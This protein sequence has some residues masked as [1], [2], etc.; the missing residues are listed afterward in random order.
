M[1]YVVTQIAVHFLAI[2]KHILTFLIEQLRPFPHIMLY[3]HTYVTENFL[4]DISLKQI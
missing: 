3:L 2:F 4:E 1:F